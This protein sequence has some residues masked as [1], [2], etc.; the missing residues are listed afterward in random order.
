MRSKMDSRGPRNSQRIDKKS[1]ASSVV[2]N[3]LKSELE[4]VKAKLEEL[5]SQYHE[6]YSVSK[7]VEDG[8]QER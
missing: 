3:E 5:K 4:S 7:R 8:G 2:K 6:L 1:A